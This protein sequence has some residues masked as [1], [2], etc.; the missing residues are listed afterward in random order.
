MSKSLSAEQ[1]KKYHDNGYL[2]PAVAI[3]PDKAAHYRRRLE[4]S[5]AALGPILKDGKGKRSHLLFT[6]AAELI[7]EP[8]ILDAVEDIIGPDILVFNLSLFPKDA[9]D[10]S[11]VSWHQDSTYHALEPEVQVSAWVALSNASIEAG[12][13]EVVP[14]SHQ[15]GQLPH[16]EI[17]DS[18][19]MLSRGQTIVGGTDFKK[20]D[21]MPLTP[22]QISLH[23]SYLLHWSAPNKSSDRR[24]GVSISYIPTYCKSKS[25][26]RQT[27]SLVRGQDTYGHF[28]PEPAPKAD[29]DEAARAAHKDAMSRYAAM[30]EKIAS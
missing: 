28:D 19:N 2:A 27:A 4:A 21:F 5:E 11:F 24:I 10:Q 20:T 1:L 3:G 15:L 23:H 8:V 13:M 22:G 6:W 29:Y 17:R 9:H 25:P 30:R 12:C 16:Q 18:R 7:R 26:I 14:G